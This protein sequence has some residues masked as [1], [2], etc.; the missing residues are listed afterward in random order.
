MALDEE[1]IVY[2]LL[3]STILA[4]LDRP[5]PRE[6]SVRF[7]RLQRRGFGNVHSRPTIIEERIS[8][9]LTLPVQPLDMP[10]EIS[11]ME[12]SEAEHKTE[13]KKEAAMEYLLMIKPSTLFDKFMRRVWYKRPISDEGDAPD[14]AENPSIGVDLVEKKTV[15]PDI[16]TSHVVTTDPQTVSGSNAELAED[17]KL[18]PIPTWLSEQ[19]YGD[20]VSRPATLEQCE[21]NVALICDVSIQERSSAVGDSI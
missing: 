2:C 15:I 5:L 20:K 1:N 11:P 10:A 21:R 16:D 12:L 9:K 19:V 17:E 4:N 13:E 18:A 14:E 7:D 6:K 8:L 3:A